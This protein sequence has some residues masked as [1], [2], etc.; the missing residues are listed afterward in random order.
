MKTAWSD[1][2]N[3]K[4]IDQILLSLKINPEMWEAV[5][6]VMREEA[7]E[8]AR[9]AAWDAVSVAAREA[10]RDAARVAAWDAATGRA[11]REEAWVAA[12]YA[13]LA[14]IAYDRTG[15][16]FN[17]SPD[18][19]KILAALGDSA[20]ILVEPAVRKLNKGVDQN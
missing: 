20:A 6:V 3:A 9:N 7:R 11:A 15:S 4:Y 19:V 1:L 12:W 5:S 14:L 16:L 13:I 10:V 17:L 18:Q 8:E 2:P